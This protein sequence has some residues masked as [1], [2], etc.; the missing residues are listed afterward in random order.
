MTP[1]TAPTI[2]PL[3]AEPKWRSHQ[4]PTRM[5]APTAAIS[6]KPI[7]ASLV[8]FDPPLT[9]LLELLLGWSAM[10]SRSGT[11]SP[12]LGGRSIPAFPPRF[13]GACDFFHKV[14]RGD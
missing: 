6:S 12:L 13:K 4:V 5:K 8:Q 14:V 7:P 1:N 10:A 11:H 3:G 9:F 2:K